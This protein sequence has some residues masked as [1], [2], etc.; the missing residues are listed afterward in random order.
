ML[1]PPLVLTVAAV[2]IGLLPQLGPAV[3]AGATCGCRTSRDTRPPCCPGNGWRTRP[4]RNHRRR[5]GSPPRTWPRAPGSAAGAVVLA[6]RCTGG[7]C[8]CSAGP[9]G[10]ARALSGF[11]RVV[12]SGVVN[13]YVAWAV[14][15]LAVLGG[16]LALAIR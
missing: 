3:Q 6:W 16:T 13:D 15:G 5:P 9:P 2:V 10:R 1:V 4:R 8:R 7:G 11:F 12:Q 14:L